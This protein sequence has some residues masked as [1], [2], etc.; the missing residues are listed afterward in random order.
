MSE[1]RKPWA[2]VALKNGKMRGVIAADLPPKDIRKFYG[3]F[4]GYDMK[5]VYNRDEYNALLKS[6]PTE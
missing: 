5:T 4:A 6:A 1:D 3:E 2:H